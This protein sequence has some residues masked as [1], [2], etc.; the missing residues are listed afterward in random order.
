MLYVVHRVEERQMVSRMSFF[1]AH[2]PLQLLSRVDGQVFC[3]CS[4]P[5]R[6]PEG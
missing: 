3:R 5:M 1:P 4:M 6:Y 2:I